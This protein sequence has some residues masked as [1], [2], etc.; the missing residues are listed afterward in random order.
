M[1]VEV[2]NFYYLLQ[3]SLVD[4]DNR[5]FGI[6]LLE[7]EFELESCSDKNFRNKKI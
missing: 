2:I 5:T 3:L 1:S 4:S 6:N 7:M